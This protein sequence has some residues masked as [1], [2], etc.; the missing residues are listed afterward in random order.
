M[1]LLTFLFMIASVFAYDNTEALV[2]EEWSEQ[3]GFVEIDL[4][5]P[6]KQDQKKASLLQNLKAKWLTRSEKKS[7]A[8]SDERNLIEEH[9]IPVFEPPFETLLE[10]PLEK[11]F[12]KAP[13]LKKKEHCTIL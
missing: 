4:S 11:I 5:D 2:G 6:P 12:P 9:T 1:I 10:P 8:D 13:E 3:N 7:K